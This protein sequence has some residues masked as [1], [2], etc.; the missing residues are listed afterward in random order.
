[1]R[2]ARSVRWFAPANNKAFWEFEYLPVAEIKINRDM[3]G[4][5]RIAYGTQWQVE[6]LSDWDDGEIVLLAMVAHQAMLQEHKRW[7]LVEGKDSKM[8]SKERAPAPSVTTTLVVDNTAYIS[9]SAR[10]GS[11]PFLYAQ[12][13]EVNRYRELLPDAPCA[14]AVATALNN[15]KIASEMGWGHQ[16]GASCGEVWAT[17]GFCSTGTTASLEGSRV[18]AI[19][20]SKAKEGKTERLP[21][22][23]DPCGT[24]VNDVRVCLGSGNCTTTGREC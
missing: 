24:W 11:G 1:L 15:C 7:L 6:G 5:K 18:V 10:G 14:G 23:V 2:Q 21:E 9:T 17:Q 4:H 13:Q 16:N 8:S 12:E 3:L 19:K 20:S 22:I